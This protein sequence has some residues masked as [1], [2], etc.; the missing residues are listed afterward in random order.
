MIKLDLS[1]FHLPQTFYT[2]Q[3]LTPKEDCDVNKSRASFKGLARW[4]R[5][6][7]LFGSCRR[8]VRDRWYRTII[9][10]VTDMSIVSLSVHFGPE[11]KTLDQ[12]TKF[13]MHHTYSNLL[14]RNFFSNLDH[15]Q[16]K[17]T[18][19]IHDGPK[20]F[21]V[22][23]LFIGSCKCLSP[24]TPPTHQRLNSK[25][26]VYRAKFVG[27]ENSSVTLWKYSHTHFQ[28]RHWKCYWPKTWPF[29]KDKIGNFTTVSK[30]GRS[31]SW[32]MCSTTNDV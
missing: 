5:R 15:L 22:H 4:C 28:C 27:C 32:H 25:V 31:S 17:N 2:L 30:Q 20:R 24:V 18:V 23:W 12:T 7:Y 16:V 9:S 21:I 8:V 13:Q 29:L 19:V 14:N 10:H 1:V 11:K 6:T 26:N 3:T